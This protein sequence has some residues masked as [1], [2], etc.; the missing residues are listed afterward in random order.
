MPCSIGLSRQRLQ[1]RPLRGFT[2]VELLVVIAIIAVLVS[3]LLPALNRAKSRAYTAAC[4]N[5]LKQLQ[6]C[7]QLYAGD[8]KDTLTPNN[9]VYFVSMGSGNAPVL[10]DDNLTWCR[11]LAPLDTNSITDSTSVLFRY[12]RSPQIYRCPADRSLVNG[13][14]QLRNRSY[15]MSNSINNRQSD[16]YLKFTNI[17]APANL[18]VFIDTHEN[19]IWDSTF[20]VMSPKSY[21]SQFWLD[22]PADRHSQGANISYA[23][24]HA[25][26]LRWAAPKASH[27]LGQRAKSEADLADLRLLQQKIKGSGGN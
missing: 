2:L 10:G 22:I 9:F 16:H 20:G 27:S 12:N 4:L 21:Y 1:A 13:T 24:G 19:A 15:N 23:D 5:N 11:S 3:L 25:E 7:W 6:I 14:S 8:N 26:T 18:F 17:K